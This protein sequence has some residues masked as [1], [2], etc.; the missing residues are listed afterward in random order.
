MLFSLLFKYKQ[1]CTF[2]NKKKKLSKKKN[3]NLLVSKV[4]LLA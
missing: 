1:K 2:Y 4:T 3:T